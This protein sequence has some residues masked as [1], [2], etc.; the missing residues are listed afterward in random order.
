MKT[1][2]SEDR[3][4]AER[5]KIRVFAMDPPDPGTPA[6][7]LAEAAAL[8]NCPD[9]D[10]ERLDWIA[11]S[12][13]APLGLALYLVEGQGAE[14]AQVEPETARLDGLKGHVL[15]V[16]SA[17]VRGDPA[18][19]RPDAR[20]TLVGTFDVDR[21]AV[22]FEALPAGGAKGVIGSTAKGGSDRRAMG[23]VAMAALAAMLGF[24]A[25]MVWIAR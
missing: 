8:L 6:M 18:L 12:D 23:I 24:M 5:D 7:T 21:P 19:L 9:L 16:P 2:P 14:A 20:L 22:R 17:A 15:V 4:P 11:L 1:P 10:T 25:V 3:A 13:L